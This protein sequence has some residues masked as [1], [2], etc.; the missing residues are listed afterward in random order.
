MEQ[1]FEIMQATRRFIINHIDSLTTSQLN[2][3]P[4]GFNNN[5][6]WNLAHM[7]AAQQ[8]V[9]YGR[10]ELP[11][12]IDAALFEAYKPGTKPGE[13]VDGN[14]IE[15]IKFLLL[16]TVEEL[17]EDTMKGVF[18]DFKPWT[19]RYGIAHNIMDDTLQFLLF[20]DGLHVGYIMSLIHAL[21]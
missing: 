16:S 19:N 4:A 13:M 10:N 2:Q 5:V 8:G 12:K 21:K 15:N 11:M 20:H 14:K 18:Q 3:V 9:C 1:V 17:K 7:V 6:I